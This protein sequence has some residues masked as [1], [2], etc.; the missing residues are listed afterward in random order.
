M[1]VTNPKNRNDERRYW[2]FWTHSL[3]PLLLCR[4]NFTH[5]AACVIVVYTYANSMSWKKF[6]VTAFPHSN[7]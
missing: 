2:N 6:V 5:I 7:H 4:S 3:V 1:T